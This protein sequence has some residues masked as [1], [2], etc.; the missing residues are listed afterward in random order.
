MKF[1]YWLGGYDDH[2][3]RRCRYHVKITCHQPVTEDGLEWVGI[4]W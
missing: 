1:E 3:L 2:L 4:G